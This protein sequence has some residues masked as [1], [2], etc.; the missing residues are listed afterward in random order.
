MLLRINPFILVRFSYFSL[1]KAFKNEGYYCD[2][3]EFEVETKHDCF[4][5]G[6]DWVKYSFNFSSLVATQYFG[7]IFAFMEGW[8]N[9]VMGVMNFNG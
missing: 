6:G 2:N 5:L 3:V 8:L 1:C 4:N 7:I 9:L